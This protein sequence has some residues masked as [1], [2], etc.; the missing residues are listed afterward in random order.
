MVIEAISDYTRSS[1]FTEGGS[2]VDGNLCRST[3]SSYLTVRTIEVVD[4]TNLWFFV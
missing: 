3:A 4:I 2:R 1:L